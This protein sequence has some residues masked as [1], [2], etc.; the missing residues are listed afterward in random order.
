M[1]NIEKR[2]LGLMCNI[3]ENKIYLLKLFN[4]ISNF[5]RITKSTTKDQ[6]KSDDILFLSIL[7]RGE[8]IIS[9]LDMQTR[10]LPGYK[11]DSL[12]VWNADI[13]VNPFFPIRSEFLN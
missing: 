8:H 10:P 9:I 4:I 7:I 3:Y 13:L 6:N 5:Y 1:C 2:E 12:G 11:N